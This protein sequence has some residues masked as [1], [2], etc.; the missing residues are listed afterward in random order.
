LRAWVVKPMLSRLST[1]AMPSKDLEEKIRAAIAGTMPAD[2]PK[3][4]KVAV[5]NLLRKIAAEYDGTEPTKSRATK[6]KR[7][8]AADAVVGLDDDEKEE[9]LAARVS[10]EV[11]EKLLAAAVPL[12]NPFGRQ[13]KP[14]LGFLMFDPQAPKRM[15]WDFA[16]I[17]PCLG[18]LTLIMPFRMCFANGNSH[19][20]HSHALP[21]RALARRARKKHT[22]T[23]REEWSV[24]AARL[25]GKPAGKV[26]CV[27]RGGAEVGVSPEA[28]AGP[29]PCAHRA[30]FDGPRGDIGLVMGSV[31]VWGVYPH[32]PFSPSMTSRAPLPAGRVRFL[33]RPRETFCCWRT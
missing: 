33:Q 6:K 16:V 14:E 9:A 17:M 1:S 18:Y 19:H 20:A 21:A 4:K 12:T 8:A 27:M 13:N 26:W 15:M 28:W 3:A 7:Q 29:P 32:A 23:M 25:L 24:A 31:C 22:G 5:A 30:P 11:D 10:A 2:P